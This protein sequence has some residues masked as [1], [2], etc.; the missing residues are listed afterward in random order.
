MVSRF[1]EPTLEDLLTDPIVH[2][3]MR[4]DGLSRTLVR[5]WMEGVRTRYMARLMPGDLQPVH[6]MTPILTAT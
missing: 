4:S 2:M 3:V 1:I 6:L 5:A